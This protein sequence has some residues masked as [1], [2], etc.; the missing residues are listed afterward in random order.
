MRSDS[1]RESVRNGAL[2]LCSKVKEWSKGD[3]EVGS[4]SSRTDTKKLLSVITR[5]SEIRHVRICNRLYHFQLFIQRL[6]CQK[7]NIYKMKTKQQIR[8]ETLARVNRLNR[9]S[10]QQ[11]FKAIGTRKK[12]DLSDYGKGVFDWSQYFKY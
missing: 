3:Y 12:F 10:K 4:C 9:K 11:K 6:Y 7:T 8:R 1:F 2:F 5:L